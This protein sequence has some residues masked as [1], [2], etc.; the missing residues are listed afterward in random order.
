M[1][2]FYRGICLSENN[3]DNAIS[4]PNY[5]KFKNYWVR[6]ECWLRILSDRGELPTLTPNDE[7]YIPEEFTPTKE[8]EK[9]YRKKFGLLFKDKR[10]RMLKEGIYSEDISKDKNKRRLKFS[11]VLEHDYKFWADPTNIYEVVEDLEKKKINKTLNEDQKLGFLLVSSTFMVRHEFGN[12]MGDGS[13]RDS[14]KL[15]RQ[16]TKKHLV[17]RVK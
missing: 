14:L 6:R 16:P 5:L 10:K 12:P 8:H 3:K 4:Q 9:F 1:A 2:H 13:N 15:K 17:K 11:K 7:I